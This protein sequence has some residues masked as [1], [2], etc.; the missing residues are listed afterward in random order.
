MESMII[1]NKEAAVM[2]TTKQN[3]LVQ[4]VLAVKMIYSMGKIHFLHPPM[5]MNVEISC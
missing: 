4:E 3:V 1:K 5:N 2:V